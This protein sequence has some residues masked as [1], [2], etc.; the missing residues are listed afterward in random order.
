MCLDKTLIWNN[1]FLVH[2]LSWD[3]VLEFEW[4]S[5]ESLP[6][7]PTVVIFFSSPELEQR[8]CCTVAT[9]FFFPFP[10]N[11]FS[12]FS[13]CNFQQCLSSWP[14]FFQWVQ[15][16]FPSSLF[17]VEVFLSFLW[18]FPLNSLC[19]NLEGFFVGFSWTCFP[20]FS[21]IV[22][23]TQTLS[24]LVGLNNSKVWRI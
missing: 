20:L 22:A 23:Y 4:A 11:Y 12:L 19:G 8:S 10:S 6:Y 1:S 13:G 21:R 16:V 14:L 2:S 24:R 17:I 3:S 18:N 7:T 5:R 15:D 9:I